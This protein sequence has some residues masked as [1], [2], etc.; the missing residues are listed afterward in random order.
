MASVRGSSWVMLGR[1]PL[2]ADKMLMSRCRRRVGRV[3][4]AQPTMQIL[5]AGRRPD[6]VKLVAAV[7]GVENVSLGMTVLRGSGASADWPS[8]SCEVCR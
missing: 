7:Q 2:D 4:T 3:A 5:G 1:L 6:E 8:A